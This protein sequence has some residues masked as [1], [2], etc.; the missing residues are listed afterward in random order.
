MENSNVDL[1]VLVKNLESMDSQAFENKDNLSVMSEENEVNKSISSKS[2]MEKMDGR[3]DVMDGRLDMMDVRLNHLSMEM[4]DG[5]TRIELMIENFMANKDSSN[6]G[7]GEKKN[8]NNY[9]DSAMEL[10]QRKELVSGL[11][12]NKKDETKGV[13]DLKSKDL[14]INTDKLF[15]EC[16]EH[17]ENIH[18]SVDCVCNDQ[19]SKDVELITYDNYSSYK[20]ENQDESMLPMNI[21]TNNNKLLEEQV[22]LIPNMGSSLVRDN[23]NNFIRDGNELVYF[24][25]YDDVVPMTMEEYMEYEIEISNEVSEDISYEEDYIFE[26]TISS[27]LKDLCAELGHMLEKKFDAKIYL[28]KHELIYIGNKITEYTKTECEL[29]GSGNLYEETVYS[30]IQNEILWYEDKYKILSAEIESYIKSSN[31]NVTSSRSLSD[32]ECSLTNKFPTLNVLNKLV[33]EHTNISISENKSFSDNM[34]ME[35]SHE[36]DSPI[37]YEG[38]MT[39]DS[40]YDTYLES[41]GQSQTLEKLEYNIGDVQCLKN[42]MI[43]KLSSELYSSNIQSQTT[44]TSNGMLVRKLFQEDSNLNIISDTHN[45]SINIFSDNTQATDRN[46]IFDNMVISED[47]TYKE[48]VLDDKVIKT[49]YSDKDMDNSYD[50]LD[51]M[52]TLDDRSITTDHT[53]MGSIYNRSYMDGLENKSIIDDYAYKDIRRL[54][55]IN[56]NEIKV[57]GTDSYINSYRGNG[58]LILDSNSGVTDNVNHIQDNIHVEENLDVMFSNKPMSI[59]NHGAEGNLLY[60]DDNSNVNTINNTHVIDCTYTRKGLGFNKA[61]RYTMGRHGFENILMGIHIYF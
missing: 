33:K 56:Y 24:A 49:D 17:I 41:G 1:E 37:T 36:K 10:E 13:L 4:R 14:Q 48:E 29:Y 53:Y 40:V 31:T 22:K 5:F 58:S 50:G 30:D 9:Y 15:T 55:G 6:E 19:I 57:I 46:L 38:V 27:Y 11:V 2:R 54:D 34:L 3:L 18:N 39:P 25:I 21:T 32:Q 28:W 42:D 47:Y 12:R 44:N 61:S 26:K 23:N 8:N 7:Q 60:S 16:E 20:Y 43:C 59:T 45:V 52:D 35:E 51:D